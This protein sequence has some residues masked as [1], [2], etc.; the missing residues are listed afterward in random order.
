MNLYVGIAIG[1]KEE[2]AESRVVSV[3]A[4]SHPEAVGMLYMWAADQGYDK[5]LGVSVNVQP[6]DRESIKAQLSLVEKP[7]ESV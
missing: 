3:F 1:E 6:V 7:D 2:K 5:V 4:K